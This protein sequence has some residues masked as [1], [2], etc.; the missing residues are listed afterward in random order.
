VRSSVSV[1]ARTCEHEVVAR[2]STALY[3]M[4]KQGFLN[5]QASMSDSKSLESR[6]RHRVMVVGH[7]QATVTR[8]PV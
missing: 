7:D 3:V 2:L 6:V 1:S 5:S 4:L 8:V